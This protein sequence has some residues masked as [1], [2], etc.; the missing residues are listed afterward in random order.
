MKRGAVGVAC[1]GMVPI[2]PCQ[3]AQDHNFLATLS[4]LLILSLSY[5]ML[6]HLLLCQLSLEI[7]KRK[8]SITILLS[9]H[10]IHRWNWKKTCDVRDGSASSGHRFSSDVRTSTWVTI[11][12]QTFQAC[13]IL[14]VLA[15][16]ASKR[17]LWYKPYLEKWVQKITQIYRIITIN[18]LKVG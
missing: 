18:C 1:S 16:I 5:R 6:I 10:T 4:F 13:E 12:T 2:L 7:T 14:L 8:S 11:I 9:R 3:P 15:S 17:W